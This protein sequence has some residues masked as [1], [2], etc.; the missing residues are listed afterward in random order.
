[1]TAHARVRHIGKS[2]R[3]GERAGFR[4]DI[5]DSLMTLQS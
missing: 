2:R 3:T 1:V 5:I 4:E